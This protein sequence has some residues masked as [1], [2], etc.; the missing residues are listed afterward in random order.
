MRDFDRSVFVAVDH[1]AVR[2][3]QP[4]LDQMA[5]QR[6]AGS[7]SLRCVRP[8]VFGSVVGVVDLYQ[9]RYERGPCQFLELY[10][11][12]GQR[13]IAC[14]LANAASTADRIAPCS[15]PSSRA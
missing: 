8:G 3:Q 13:G 5:D 14:A 10:P 6:P 9:R 4:R 7:G 15:P 1:A 11:V 2:N 12:M